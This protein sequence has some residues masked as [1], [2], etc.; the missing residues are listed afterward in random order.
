MKIWFLTTEFPPFYGGGIGTYMSHAVQMFAAAGH[1]VTVFVPGEENIEQRQSA[2]I[3]LIRFRPGHDDLG[4]AA[5]S[6]EPDAHPAFPF[7]VMSYWPAMSYRF[8]IEVGKLIAREGPPDLIEVQ[9]YSGIG[10]YLLQQ[11]LL[12]QAGLSETLIL[13][14]LHT[15]GFEILALDR[16]PDYRLP[17]YWVGRMERFSI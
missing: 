9:D 10:Y 4:K 1:E 8:A 17:E 12:G 6:P 5:G 3:R 11:K 14:H 15:P 7:N 2:R 16:F 13:V